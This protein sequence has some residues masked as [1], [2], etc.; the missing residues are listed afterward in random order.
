MKQKKISEKKNLFP[1]EINTWGKS[2]FGYSLINLRNK[3]LQIPLMIGI[4][5]YR[6]IKWEEIVGEEEISRHPR[7]IRWGGKARKVRFGKCVLFPVK[8]LVLYP[9]P[10]TPSSSSNPFLFVHFSFSFFILLPPLFFFIF[11]NLEK[12]YKNVIENV[13]RFPPV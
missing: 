11:S 3:N 4:A 13:P 7:I 6:E 8:I 5:G 10:L 9:P 12:L 1:E 2:K